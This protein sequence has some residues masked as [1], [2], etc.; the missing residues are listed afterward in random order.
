MSQLLQK[1]EIKRIAT[2]V[3]NGS[4]IIVPKEW[5]G[6]EIVLT[7]IIESDPKKEILTILEP[8]FE[9]IIGVYIYGSYARKESRKGSDIDI[10]VITDK[11][12]SGIEVKK[13]FD[14][15]FLE[16]EKIDSLKKRNP[17][18]FYSFLF[19]AE[20]ILNAGYLEQLRKKE[21]K[22]VK[23]YF[24]DYLEDSERVIKINKGFLELDQS[25]NVKFVDAN[26]I[27]SLILRLRGMFIIDNLLKGE[28]FSNN[29][30][31]KILRDKLAHDPQSYYDLYRAFIDNRKPKGKIYV[32]EAGKFI[33]L[34]DEQLREVKRIVYAK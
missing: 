26:L 6:Y 9:N 27:Y 19:E 1:E 8:Y 12:I 21:I 30:F 16:E 2:P 17:V 18:L 3:G 10:M 24:M 34:L 32:L 4:H 14:I 33:N 31:L 28:K 23:R 22:V 20:P 25:S 15:T 11:K 13:P 7:R 29:S 5:E